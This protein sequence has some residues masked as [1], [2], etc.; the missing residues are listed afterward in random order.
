V[1]FELRNR[2][3]LARADAVATAEGSIGARAQPHAEL[4]EPSPNY[5][6]AD[7]TYPE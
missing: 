6:A 5:G 4:L 2:T 7:P 3:I 1:R